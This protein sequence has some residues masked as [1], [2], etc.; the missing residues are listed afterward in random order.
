M[1]LRASRS[2]SAVVNEEMSQ[3]L[4]G[5]AT[6]AMLAPWVGILGSIWGIMNS[7]PAISGSKSFYL[8]IVARS[9]SKSMWPTAFGLLVGITALS[10]YR[11]L[12]ERLRHFDHEMEDASL[13]LIASLARQRGLFTLGVAVD[14][15]MF[16]EKT[17]AE[18]EG[19]HRFWRRSLFTTSTA[20]FIAWFLQALRYLSDIEFSL[21][22]VVQDSCLYILF[23]FGLSCLLVYP[24]WVRLLHR[25]RGGLVALGSVFCLCWTVS[26]FVV[27][28]HLP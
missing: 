5:L 6:I 9:L 21:Y 28:R 18:L 20:L 11:H 16:G 14:S 27:G 13:G 23:T 3:G 24:A 15:P 17:R 22:A 10:C 1:V 4:N 12:T 26:E 19:D 25:R 7:F 2:S 8:A